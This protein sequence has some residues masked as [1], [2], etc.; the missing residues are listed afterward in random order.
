MNID[1]K[2]RAVIVT[3]AASGLGRATALAL[4]EEGARVLAVDRNEQGLAETA[5]Q[6]GGRV[7][8][9]AADLTQAD[10]CARVIEEGVARFGGLD[11]LCNIAGVLKIE[12][13][14]DVTPETWDLI[15]A[16]NVRAPFFLSKAAMPHLIESGGAIVNVSSATAFRGYAYMAAYTSSKAA[17]AHLTKSMAAEFIKTG[18]RINAIAPGQ[19]NTPMAE[20]G[21]FND[22]IDFELLARSMA[23]RGGSDPENYTGM[24]LHLISPQN[25]IV[26]GA[27]IN[28]D[29]GFV[30]T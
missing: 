6:A 29:D 14:E 23:V 17:I 9:F 30:A 4:S 2:D 8:T 5:K 16:V 24:I 26:R 18:V 3:G 28:I 10:A 21:E 20:G 27:C 7:T 19:V 12:P 1:L 13:V 11:A 25:T 22:K 15:Y